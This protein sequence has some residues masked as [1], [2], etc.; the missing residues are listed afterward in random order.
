MSGQ[1]VSTNF[2][3]R[4]ETHMKRIPMS[5]RT[6]CDNCPGK[7]RDGAWIDWYGRKLYLCPRCLI[8]A[9]NVLKEAGHEV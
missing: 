6:K 9:R 7:S 2:G 5:H 1:G 3:T 8:A 4:S